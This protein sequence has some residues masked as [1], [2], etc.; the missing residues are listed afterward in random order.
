MKDF[1]ISELDEP[2]KF[3]VSGDVFVA[4]AP[5]RLP[6]NVLVRYAEGV[7]IGRVH[8]AHM[9]LFSDVLDEDSYKLF[10]DRLDSSE[11]PITLHTMANITTWL[12]EEIYS[13]KDTGLL[14]L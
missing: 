6:A 8:S 3:S 4:V 11:N 12:V 5:A 9:R 7:T 13:G 1:Q 2:V 14:S 10:A